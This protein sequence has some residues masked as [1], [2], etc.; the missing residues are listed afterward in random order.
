MKQV[1]QT[2]MG[3]EGNCLSACIASLL[4][5]SVDDVPHFVIHED[6]WKRMQQWLYER[7][8]YPYN[9]AVDDP[10]D[11]ANTPDGYYIITGRSPSGPCQHCVVACGP[12]IVHDPHPKRAGLATRDEFLVLL[13]LD[14]G[15]WQRVAP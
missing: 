9:F 10:L 13:P 5:L 1:D 12:V 8:L 14:V 15:E 4:H 2:I 3:P 7:G 11:A 6:A